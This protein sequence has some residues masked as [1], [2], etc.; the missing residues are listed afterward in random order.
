VISWL[1]FLS[2]FD[3]RASLEETAMKSIK[4]SMKKKSALAGEQQDELVPFTENY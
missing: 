2:F 4:E 1:I 3:I